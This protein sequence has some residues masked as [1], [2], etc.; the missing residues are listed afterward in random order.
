MKIN[1]IIMLS[2]HIILFPLE[3]LEGSFLVMSLIFLKLHVA[4]LWF[5]VAF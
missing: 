5:N 2:T 1:N 3:N 4:M